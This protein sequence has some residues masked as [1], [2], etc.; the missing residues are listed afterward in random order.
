MGLESKNKNFSD[1]NVIITRGPHSLSIIS[2]CNKPKE[3]KID[4]SKNVKKTT[5]AGDTMT[6][7]ICS[8][9]LQG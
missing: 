4:P 6:G 2:H 7:T 9:L 8:M 1:I 3:I 5:G